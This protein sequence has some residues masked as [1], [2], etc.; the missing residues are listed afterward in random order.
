MSFAKSFD[1]MRQG[2]QTGSRRRGAFPTPPVMAYATYIGRVGALAVALGVGAGVAGFGGTAWADDTAGDP[3]NSDS[4][5]NS[6]PAGATE[7]D[8]TV[9]AAGHTAAN[10]PAPNPASPKLNRTGLR[11]PRVIV[12]SSGGG[13]FPGARQSDAATLKPDATPAAKP[14]STPAPK[15]DPA[16]AP[17]G[18]GQQ[19]ASDPFEGTPIELAAPSA[20]QDTPAPAGLERVTTPALGPA[21]NVATTAS[22]AQRGQPLPQI[23]GEIST[24]VHAVDD[25]KPAHAVTTDTLTTT[26]TNVSTSA[27][28]DG[29]NFSGPQL[30]DTTALSTQPA[31]QI[32]V[33]PPVD[34]ITQVV[35][36]L[37]AFFGFSPLATNTPVAPAAPSLTLLG[38]LEWV[39]REIE[40]T[41]FNQ[42]P[43]L[44]YNPTQ[45]SFLKVGVIEGNLHPFDPDSATLTY[46]AT[47][48]AHGDVV[49]HPDGTFTYTPDA[50][51]TGPDSFDVTVSDA[52]NGFQIHGLSGL[53]H[54]VTFGL[55]GDSGD[56]YTQHITVNEGLPAGISRTVLLSGL[57]E[58]ID[59]L[60]LPDG[61]VLPDGQGEGRVLI[62]EKSGAILV[63]DRLTTGEL[64]N[65]PLI[66]L[67]VSTGGER[68]ITGF[69]LDP[70]YMDNGYVYV[71]N[72][73]TDN[74]DQVSRLT[75]TDP[76]ADVLTVDPNSVVVLL[77]ADQP[78]G[79]SHH[80]GGLDF[81]PDGKLYWALGDN[82]DPSNAQNLSTVYGKVLRL[83][84][85]HLDP[86][87]GYATAPD[88][89]PFVKTDDAN[90]YIYASGFRNPFRMTFTPDGELLVG[91]VGQANWEELDIVTAGGN[92]GWPNAEGVCPGPGVCAPASDF[93]SFVNPIYAYPHSTDPLFQNG[94]ITSVIVY[95]GSLFGESYQNKVF[96]ADFTLGWIKL[97]TCTSDYSSCGSETIFDNQAGATVKLAQE[98][99][100]DI[101]QLTIYPGQLLR[102][103]P[104]GV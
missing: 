101:Y 78:A 1:T 97:L 55:L 94:S 16:S 60:F 73:A 65:D 29:M 42:T 20:L 80:G 3:T 56:T 38:L 2:R 63:Y 53:L 30:A 46:T 75:V 41:F 84:P 54:L 92:Y 28:S 32:T 26:V 58:P 103:A 76:S 74:Y 17:A 104:S 87:T 83:D 59:F 69:A 33:A 11:P 85:Y 48:P 90:P 91:D 5:Q 13:A 27:A 43:T 79:D 95:T 40:R 44:A 50:G 34:P 93:G 39:R 14:D 82:F 36:G 99:D 15:P 25:A 51:Y 12:G 81:G 64:Q 7:T 52:N 57:N 71:A 18:S 4:G 88:D 96:I 37:L 22:P 77:R 67:P 21:M 98:A 19:P 100:G 62:A 6:G 49:A 31:P 9:G 72:T 66:K 45:N 47:D 24:R 35:S 102:I 86:V 61:P 89:N 8:A 70:H 10:P 68:G 23:A